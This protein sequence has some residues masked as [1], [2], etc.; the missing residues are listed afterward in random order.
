MRRSIIYIVKTFFTI[1]A[2]STMLSSCGIL[3]QPANTENTD[4]NDLSYLYNPSKNMMNPQ[5][6]VATRSDNEATLSIMLL[7][8]ELLFSEANETG[9]PLASVDIYVRLFDVTT[10]R[11][12]TDTLH[13]AISLALDDNLSE[14]VIDIPLKTSPKAKYTVEVQITDMLKKNSHHA[15]VNFNTMSA[16]NTYNFEVLNSVDRSDIFSQVVRKDL[17]FS[18][19]YL[20]SQ[21]DSLYIRLYKSFDAI[22]DPPSIIVPQ[23]TPDY[24]PD[25]ILSLRYSD[26]IP[27]MLPNKGIYK[28]TVDSLT[29]EGITIFNFG[30][31][32]PQTTSPETMIEPLVYLTSEAELYNLRTAENKKL[33]L[34]NFWI[35]CGNN[36]EKARELIRIYYTRVYFANYYFTSF[37]EGWKTERGMI[38]VMYGPP[39][40]LYKTSEG[41]N[42]GYLKPE[43][44]SRWGNRVQV[45]QQYIYF[46]FK[47]RDNQFTDND[48][49]LSRSESL[50]SNWSQAVSS[51]RKGV[52][53]RMDNPTDY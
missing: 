43:V 27:L 21:P 19:N 45:K 6:K 29:D 17:Y 46:N 20:K 11:I 3:S 24:E 18:I 28:F 35:S 1:I 26:N 41:E 7:K 47:Q 4:P 32:Y 15:F 23:K 37:T 36:I 50:I 51:W 33:A 10:N 25:T 2:T 9:K 52:V 40:K 48:Y 12:L 30:P 53:F 38:Y 44:K 49:Y 14:Y 42:W 5:F 8:N 31:E 16:L 39:D 22:P 13:S 34:D